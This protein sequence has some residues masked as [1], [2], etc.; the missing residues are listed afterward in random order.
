MFRASDM[1]V[2]QKSANF[3]V[4]Y[5]GLLCDP[6]ARASCWQLSWSESYFRESF[7]GPTLLR[8]LALREDV[9]G[10][11]RCKSGSDLS[12]KASLLLSLR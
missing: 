5:E 7:L 10:R 1:Q 11:K 2:Y 9:G 4:G 6:R 3:K 8:L 12:E